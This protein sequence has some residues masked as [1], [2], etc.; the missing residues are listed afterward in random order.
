MPTSDSEPLN[1]RAQNVLR[2]VVYSYILNAEPVSSR[3][4]AKQYDMSAATIRNVLAD[5][6]D[7][8][9]LQQPHTSAG[10]VPTARGYHVFIDSLMQDR[11]LPVG[12]RVLIEKSLGGAGDA[13]AVA[14][15]ASHLL[16]ELSS[17]VGI[18][19]VPARGDVVLR[20]VD[21]VPLPGLK[22]LCV[23][24]SDTGF[25]DNRVIDIDQAIGRDELVRMSNYL[26]QNFAGMTLFEARRRLVFLMGDERAQVD[27]LMRQS[28]LL[29]RRGLDASPEPG[30]V[31]E[32]AESLLDQPELADL[33]RVRKLFETFSDKAQ[34]VS[35]LTKCVEGE[36]VRVL[37][38]NDSALTSELD[39]S[40]VATQYGPEEQPLGSL[41]V[42]GPSR[43]EYPRLIPLVHFLGRA[44]SS[45]LEP[46]VARD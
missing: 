26:T 31:L 20:S 11:D 25:V 9:L 10:R 46:G 39:F 17:Q 23:V 30:V 41:G 15:A 3:A 5:L 28:I 29:A 35:M 38:G 7:W 13:Q 4:V 32:G 37:I 21:F 27:S 19:L 45:V 8:G 43:M 6:D 22:V 16:S 44:V 34:L 33:E 36:G 40:L 14:I 1:E 12:Q 24:V 18:V 2:E 42:F